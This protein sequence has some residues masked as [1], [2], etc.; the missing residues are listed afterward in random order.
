MSQT[1]SSRFSWAFRRASCA[2]ASRQEARR[3]GV[4]G[5][6]VVPAPRA[7]ILL[8]HHLVA[9]YTRIGLG[10]PPAKFETRHPLPNQNIHCPR[11][12]LQQTTTNIHT[13]PP[14]KKR[15]RQPEKCLSPTADTEEAVL[16]PRVTASTG[17]GLRDG[18]GDLPD[19]S[20]GLG[21]RLVQQRAQHLRAGV[22]PRGGAKRSYES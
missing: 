2:A 7:Q 9:C 21:L 17:P 16:A 15:K 20:F 11:T 5:A 10:Y 4:P 12:S 18:E 6:Q 13:D 1:S 19:L 22:H 14:H 8:N 3:A